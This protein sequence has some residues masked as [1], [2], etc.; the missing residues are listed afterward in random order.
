MKILGH[1]LR[2][3]VVLTATHLLV[4]APSLYRIQIILHGEPHR[5]FVGYTVIVLVIAGVSVLFW[6]WSNHLLKDD[7]R[8]RTSKY[9]N[10]HRQR[11]SNR[12]SHASAENNKGVRLAN[13]T[14]RAIPEVIPPSDI[15]TN[16]KQRSFLRWCDTCSDYVRTVHHGLC[17]RCGTWIDP[18]G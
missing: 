10:T 6:K 1:L 14:V 9:V 4:I 18:T 3:A 7:H 5:F 2:L 15:R 8:N 12:P 16:A 17:S 13:D 11:E